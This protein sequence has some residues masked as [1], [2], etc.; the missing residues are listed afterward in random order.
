MTAPN[1][2]DVATI[3]GISYCADLSTTLTT[4]LITGASENVNKINLIR[5]TNV[6]DNDATTT[7][8]SEVGG[9]HKKLCN[10]LTVPANSS[11]DVIDKNASFYL[12]ETDLIRGGASAASTL[13]VTISYEKMAD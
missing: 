1:I 7:I 4:T 11:V 13:E 3:L 2:V 6:T 9:T 8:D 10:E 5:V 12:Q